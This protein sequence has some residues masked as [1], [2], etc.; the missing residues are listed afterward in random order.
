MIVLGAF[1]LML[2]GFSSSNGGEAAYAKA[3]LKEITDSG[4]GNIYD[5]FR[6]LYIFI[7]IN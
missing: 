7:Q 1:G 3:V 5:I 4:T 6:Y 2:L